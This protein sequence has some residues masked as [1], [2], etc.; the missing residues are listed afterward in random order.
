MNFGRL[1][2][3]GSQSH[4]KNKFGTGYELKFHCGPGKANTVEQFVQTNIK[5]AAHIETYAGN[6]V[7]TVQYEWN[8][9]DLSLINNIDSSLNQPTLS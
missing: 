8:Q 2:C 4:L 6:G 3:I 5:G 9:L 1:C 7:S